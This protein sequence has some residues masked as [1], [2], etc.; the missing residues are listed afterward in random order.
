MPQQI[1]LIKLKGKIDG[2]SFYESG[3][4]LLA[5]MAKGPSKDR[6]KRDPAFARTRQNNSE[7]SGC[8]KVAKAFRSAFVMARSMSDPYI[9]SR[10][11]GIFKRIN[12]SGKGTRGQRSIDL[13]QHREQLTGFEF[14][15]DLSL[16]QLYNGLIIA[17]HADDRASASIT[18][19]NVLLRNVVKAPAGATHIKFTQTLGALSDYAYD[20]ISNGYAPLENSSASLHR[21]THSDYQPL[22]MLQPFSL[23]LTSTL[24]DQPIVNE[25]MSVIQCFAVAFYTQMGNNF[26]PL[27]NMGAMK[28]VGIF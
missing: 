18:I 12:I 28:V 16:S 27:K 3:G 15:R 9:S 24:S 13:S 21:V 25:R 22:D 17:K 7:F 20:E 2:I 6:I 4:N 5:R 8:A 23:N 11:T 26:Y 19:E 1:G 14:N 10:L